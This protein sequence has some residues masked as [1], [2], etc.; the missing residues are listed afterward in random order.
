MDK[1]T[2]GCSPPYCVGESAW[3][4]CFLLKT[5]NSLCVPL[6]NGNGRMGR[7]CSSL[8]AARPPSPLLLGAADSGH[9]AH[10]APCCAG[11]EYASNHL[12]NFL[13]IISMMCDWTRRRTPDSGGC[14]PII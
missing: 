14:P 10:A 3:L 13:A 5:P 1:L 8:A 2:F 9:A 7:R 11:K 6:L 4:Y 12:M